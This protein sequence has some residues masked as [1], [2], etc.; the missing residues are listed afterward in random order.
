MIFVLINYLLSFSLLRKPQLMRLQK[1]TSAIHMQV[2]S[3]L[4]NSRYC[5]DTNDEI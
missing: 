2:S 5:S 1:K 3:L 4:Q